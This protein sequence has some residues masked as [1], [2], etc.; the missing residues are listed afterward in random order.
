MGW[1]DR[2][3]WLKTTGWVNEDQEDYEDDLEEFLIDIMED[4]EGF[5][6]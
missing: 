3:D 1:E 5:D 6:E 4:L 2:L